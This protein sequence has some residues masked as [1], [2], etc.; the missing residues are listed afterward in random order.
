MKH[1]T[2][3]GATPSVSTPVQLNGTDYQVAN[4]SVAPTISLCGRITFDGNTLYQIN[5]YTSSDTPDTNPQYIL[6][7]GFFP[8]WTPDAT[9]LLFLVLQLFGLLC[10]LLGLFSTAIQLSV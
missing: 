6:M 5:I 10:A 4:F 9:Y 8:V 1:I 3:Y 7:K 2:L